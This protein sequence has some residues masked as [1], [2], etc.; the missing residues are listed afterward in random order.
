MD[1][2]RIPLELRDIPSFTTSYGIVFNIDC[3]ILFNNIK[4]DSIDCIFADPPFN[5]NKEYGKG[6]TDNMKKEEYLNWCFSWIDDCIRVLKEGGALFLYNIPRWLYHYCSYLDDKMVFRNWIAMTMKNTY[7][8]GNTLYPAHYGL[9]YFTKGKPRVF[10]KIRLPIPICRHCKKEIKD[11]GGHRD[12]LNSKGLNL[13]D[14]WEDTS[15]VRHNKFKT[16]IANE[17]KPMIPNRAIQMSTK[18]GDIVLDP[19]GGGGSTFQE[20]QSI[21]RYWL[22][23]EIVSLKPIIERMNIKSPIY[24]SQDPPEK[25]L[26]V[27]K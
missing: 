24:S 13:T 6:F 9:I 7:P 21:E 20:A 3:Q 12:K 18:K 5:L 26:E 16:R 4:D 25:V 14:F 15:P 27:F 8:R 2:E 10:N 23:S 11:Y 22:G 1:E 19:F 17:L